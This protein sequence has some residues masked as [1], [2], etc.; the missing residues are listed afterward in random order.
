MAIGIVFVINLH[1][2]DGKKH[3]I[4]YSGW[5]LNDR[6]DKNI[7]FKPVITKGQWSTQV[8]S[9]LGTVNSLG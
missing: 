9:D 1:I 8:M 2:V 5:P 3:F 4:S 7:T 6:T